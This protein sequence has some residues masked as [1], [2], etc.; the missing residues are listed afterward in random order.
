MSS[1]RSQ[2]FTTTKELSD[3]IVSYLREKQNGNKVNIT[4]IKRKN[5]VNNTVN[6][7]LPPMPDW[8]D[9]TFK[10]YKG[11][12]STGYHRS[13]MD[14]KGSS[15]WQGVFFNTLSKVYP[16]DRGYSGTRGGKRRRN[17]KRKTQ[18]SV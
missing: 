7:P 13:K 15:V 6:V 9:V 10:W 18:K 16:N 12:E 3:A 1:K 2:K 11:N 17:Q 4:S 8:F 14:E 5:G